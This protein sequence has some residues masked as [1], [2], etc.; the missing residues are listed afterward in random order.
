MVIEAEDFHPV[1]ETLF[2]LAMK[3]VKESVQ[4]EYPDLKLDFLAVEGEKEVEDTQSGTVHLGTEGQQIDVPANDEV[5][6]PDPEKDEGEKQNKDGSEV[7][8]HLLED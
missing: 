5:V 8:I 3:S 2:N 4:A 1:R 6:D 7:D